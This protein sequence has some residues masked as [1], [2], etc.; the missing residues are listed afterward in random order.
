MSGCTWHTVNSTTSPSSS[1]VS[2]AQHLPP[3]SPTPLSSLSQQIQIAMMIENSGV[4]VDN[5]A[6]MQMTEVLMNTVSGLNTLR[7][8]LGE[9]VLGEFL[10]L[11]LKDNKREPSSARD[12]YLPNGLLD[13]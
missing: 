8:A 9:P 13:N 12:A 11:L 10:A 4:G 5:N 6:A 2:L 1:P 7:L 3:A